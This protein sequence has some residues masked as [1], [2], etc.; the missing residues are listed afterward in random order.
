MG[1]D[2]DLDAEERGDDGGAEERLVALVLGMGDEG[3]DGR[4]ELGP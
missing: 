2:L 4:D 1:P 3:D